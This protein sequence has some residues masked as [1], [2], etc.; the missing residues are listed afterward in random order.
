MLNRSIPGQMTDSELRRVIALAQA[1]P[2]NGVIVEVGS[3]YGLCSW[4][5]AKSCAPGVTVFCIDPWERQPWIVEQVEGPNKA[6]PFGRA[7]FEQYTADCDN[8]VV[9]Q[10]YSP[11]VARGWHLP[12]DLYVED[13]VHTNPVLS[14][15]IKFWG[16]MV[17]PG[18]VISGHDYTSIWPD[19]IQEANTLA[20]VWDSA[21][22]VTD[23]LWSIPKP[24]PIIAA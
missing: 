6:P 5:L 4:H 24:K 7:A 17:R 10:G 2:E 16:G 22:S 21:L 3:L 14:A 12:I 8:I 18:G 19:V 20:R 1:V 11:R 23:T 13:A 9:V 15:N